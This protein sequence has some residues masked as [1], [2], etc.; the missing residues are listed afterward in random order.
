MI[1]LL[2]AQ[3][4][5]GIERNL[6][7]LRKGLAETGLIEGRHF[8]IEMRSA[9]ND[10]SRLAEL[11]ADLV[12]HR[13]ALIYAGGGVVSALAAKAATTSIPIVFSM[14]DDPVASGL[15]ASFNRP[16]GNITG[17]AFLTTE[18]GAKRL[19]LL[20]ELVPGAARYA[21]LVNP[22]NPATERII[23]E[24]RSAAAAIGKQLEVFP[25][26]NNREID[27]AF[28]Q[29]VQKGADALIVGG[30]SLFP[31]RSVQVATL[32]AHH[33]LP[34][35]YYDRKTVEVGG[36]MSYGANLRDAFL[37]TGLYIGRI[38]KG[39]KPADLPVMQATKSE[40]VLNLQTA[41][42]LGLTVPPTLLALADEVIE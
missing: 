4:T 41:R 17:I 23:A 34:A 27:S 31:N 26:S 8:A 1:G 22:A 38:L 7:P 10:Y 9:E 28:A 37:Q 20:K 14:G 42:T 11:A 21:A 19:G 25:A 16:G 13:V 24:L 39:E 33:H 36:L 29:L 18:L 35:I 15:V 12:R 30:S 2:R 3:S 40:F 6:A 5:E 32:A